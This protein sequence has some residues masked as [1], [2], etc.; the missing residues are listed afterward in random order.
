M[1][2]VLYL[3]FLAFVTIVNSQNN[4]PIILK[5]GKLVT[6]FVP[7][8]W[9]II[10]KSEGDLNKDKIN[11]VAFII[12]NTATEN[13]ILNK[14]L[15]KDTLN[16]NPRFLVVLFK[17][18]SKYVLKSINKKFIPSQDVLESPCLEDPLMENGGI[19]I[20]NGVLNIDLH[21]WSSCGSWDVTD[22]KYKFRF[23]NNSFVL[24]GYDSSNFHRSTGESNSESINFISKKKELITGMNEFAE[25]NPK[26]IWKNI[27]AEKLIKLEDLTTD[28][29]ID[30]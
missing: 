20:K 12:E 9:K 19:E 13:I 2:Q 26:T 30:Y 5:E 22:R 24:I 21:Y 1:K 18:D 16:I 10:A 28:S 11:D 6:D 29:E 4:N 17:T 15:G 25:S 7:R 14:G 23:Q 3:F 8:K 27:K